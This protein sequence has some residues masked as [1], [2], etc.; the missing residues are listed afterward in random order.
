MIEKYKV[1][2]KGTRPLLMH[3]CANMLEESKN[4]TTRSKEYDPKIDA[5]KALY[6][7]ADGNIVVP[8]LCILA[9]IKDS[10]KNFKVPGRGRQTFKNF[11]F[12][13]I[14]L[15]PENIPLKSNNPWE[16]DLKP[17]VIGRSRIIRARP[18]FD[19]WELE[20]TAEIVDPV[21]TPDSLKQFIID[22][23]KYNGLL[24]FRPLYGLFELK[25]FERIVEV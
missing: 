6:K 10:A 24:D 14:R 3:S 4:K 11:V 7:D 8:S 21:I 23:G 1:R 16:I 9:C 22:A 15:D 2:I 5:E 19:N 20:F 17:V 13:G 12:A 25:T 18:R